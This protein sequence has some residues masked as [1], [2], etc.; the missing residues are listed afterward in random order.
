MTSFSYMFYEATTFNHVRVNVC[1][2]IPS[3]FSLAH[4]F[5]QNLCMWST[6]SISSDGDF[7]AFTGA[8][9]FDNDFDTKEPWQDCNEFANNDDLKNAV[10]SCYD[11][12]IVN[13]RDE[14]RCAA[15]LATYGPIGE[16]Q[17][18]AAVTDMSM[19]FSNKRGSIFLSTVVSCS[20]S[21]SDP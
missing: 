1:C 8:T 17:F 5:L 15:A 10:D 3:P 6:D 4:I 13:P 18:G 16:W 2:V 14:T 12:G 11:S 19:L 21:V 9:A 20:H 7:S